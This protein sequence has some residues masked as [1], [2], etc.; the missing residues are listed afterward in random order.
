MTQLKT[1]GLYLS[2]KRGYLAL[3]SILQRI[4]KRQVAF[5]VSARDANVQNDYFEEILATCQSREI[6]FFEKENTGRLPCDFILAV[7]W[8]SLIPEQPGTRI[9]VIHDSVLPKYRGFNPVVT[10]LIDGDVELGATAFFASEN[11]DEGDVIEQAV[12]QIAYPIK[13]GAAIDILAEV[14]GNLASNVVQKML[15]GTVQSIPQEHDKATFSLWRDEKDYLIDWSKNAN[16]IK[17]FVDAV[18]FPFRGA[19]TKWNGGRS[20]RVLDTEVV[21]DVFVHDRS[22]NIGKVIFMRDKKPVV[23]CGSGLLMLTELIDE[24]SGASLLPL[25]KFRIRFE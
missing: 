23:V 20:A 11:Y 10:A 15:N 6:L 8:R 18:G 9:S 12:V 4:D 24:E 25:K 3:Q 19:L 2:S 21:E 16:W 14:V 1:V 7:G 17:R 13:I 22:R 5:V